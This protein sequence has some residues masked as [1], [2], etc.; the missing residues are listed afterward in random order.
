MTGSIRLPRG[1]GFLPQARSGRAGARGG[2]FIAE[3]SAGGI[4]LLGHRRI[5]LCHLIHTVDG[6]VDFDE[7][8]RLFR[9]RAHDRFD[10]RRHLQHLAVDIA[11][12]LAGTVDKCH[13]RGNL[14]RRRL[15]EK[16]D[17]FGEIGGAAGKLADFL[18]DDGKTFPGVS[19]TCCFDTRIER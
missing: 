14:S 8:D 2:R 7:R 13:A 9:R 16:L 17:F 1:T 6:G 12:C 11:E 18:G 10:Q 15:D 3:L 5:L 19:G 4:R